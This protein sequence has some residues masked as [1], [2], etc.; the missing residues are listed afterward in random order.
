MVG[1]GI[2]GGGGDDD[3]D[4]HDDDHHQHHSRHRHRGGHRGRI[5]GRRLPLAA[6]GAPRSRRRRGGGSSLEGSPFS[7]NSAAGSLCSSLCG[8]LGS[9]A[10][11][12]TNSA[13]VAS[14]ASA[15]ASASASAAGSGA[16]T[17]FNNA[18]ARRKPSSFS[19]SV[20]HS[21]GDDVGEEDIGGGGGQL[22][23]GALSSEDASLIS[24]VPPFASCSA[25]SPPSPPAG[26]TQAVR[27]AEIPLEY[28]A[29]GVKLPLGAFAENATSDDMVMPDVAPDDRSSS[30][31]D[32]ATTNV[33]P[34]NLIRPIARPSTAVELSDEMLLSSL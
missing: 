24:L 21:A 29:T 12:P 31:G 16:T 19:C 3:D 18:L 20:P 1:S 11:S 7:G 6:H 2:V 13:V 22:S 8:S 15:S 34:P 4:D 23:G 9:R 33:V 10:Q 14:G 28:I 32:A 17:I 5:T 30:S 25:V 26:L 27:H